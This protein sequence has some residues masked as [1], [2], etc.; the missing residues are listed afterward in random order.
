MPIG[1]ICFY[2]SDRRRSAVACGRGPGE[3]REGELQKDIGG[4]RYVHDPDCGDG[5]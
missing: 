4:D 2:N 5:L 1:F 3:R